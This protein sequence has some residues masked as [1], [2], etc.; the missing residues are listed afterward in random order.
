MDAYGDVWVHPLP[1]VKPVERVPFIEQAVTGKRVVHVGFW[2]TRGSRDTHIGE[3][4]WL[5]SRLAARAREIV[6]VDHNEEG[7]AEARAQGYEAYHVDARDP[8]AVRALGI[9]PAELVVA[10]EIIE[11]LERPGDFLDAM[12]E[13]VA[14]DGQLLITTPNAYRLTNTFVA[15]TGK[16]NMNPDHIAIYSW[17]TLKNLM[18]RHDW[19]IDESLVY[20]LPRRNT[21]AAK[22][23][24]AVQNSI[25]QRFPFLANGLIMISSKVPAKVAS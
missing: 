20:N 21:R 8:A 5:H 3:N 15:L 2:G 22:I 19:H 13:L 10:G 12:H 18:E 6:G 14:D 16:E 24:T 7:I 4:K 11:H 25:S 9:A 17:F 1:K 23:G